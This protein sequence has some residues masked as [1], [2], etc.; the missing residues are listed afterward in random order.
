MRKLGLQEAESSDQNEDTDTEEQDNIHPPLPK[1][2]KS[3]RLIK[4]GRALNANSSI[5][6]KFI[7]PHEVG[8]NKDGV[9]AEFDTL[10]IPQFVRG[11]TI[12][13]RRA[14]PS[15]ANTMTLVLEE[16]MELAELYPWASVRACHAI[17][18]QQIESGHYI[19]ASEAER[20][21]LHRS[22]IW[23]MASAKATTH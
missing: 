1:D 21:R 9:P 2:S 3:K 19:W 15:I 13:T 6:H 11:F 12:V 10:S 22:H 5:K 20:Q 18:L 17:L 14:K 7:W 8:Y 23:N 4:S 16:I